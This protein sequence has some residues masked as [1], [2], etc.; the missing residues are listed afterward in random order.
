VAVTYL[1]V[2]GSVLGG[3]S[4]ATAKIRAKIDTLSDTT[5]R[6]TEVAT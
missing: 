2:T 1:T 5:L 4:I 6:L 3:L